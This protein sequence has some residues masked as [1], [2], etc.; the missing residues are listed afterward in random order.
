MSVGR[1]PSPGRDLSQSLGGEFRAELSPSLP[2]P[3][4][5][6]DSLTELGNQEDQLL[7]QQP[8][9]EE[10]QSQLQYQH[11]PEQ[12]ER[13]RSSEATHPD[14]DATNTQGEMDST[15]QSHTKHDDDDIDGEEYESPEEDEPQSQKQRV[16]RRR[17]RPPKRIYSPERR[18]LY[19]D[20]SA[21]Q[22]R[23]RRLR[24]SNLIG[25]VQGLYRSVVTSSEG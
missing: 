21:R 4:L 19:S 11:Q 5:P 7:R 13:E 25:S 23:L 2:V 10:Q 24:T 15:E 22:N 9:Q 20:K 17:R 3:P 1:A 6:L 18:G 14:S 12:H 16:S 8:R